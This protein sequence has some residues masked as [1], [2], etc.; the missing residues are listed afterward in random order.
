MNIHSDNRTLRTLE[1]CRIKIHHIQKSK[2]FKRY[3]KRFTNE[4]LCGDY[5][6][7]AFLGYLESSM[8]DFDNV[9]RME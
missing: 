4:F 3:D 9:W 8:V 2:F 1:E 6:N 7:F 5:L